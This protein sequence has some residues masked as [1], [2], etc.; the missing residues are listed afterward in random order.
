MSGME[1]DAYQLFLESGKYG[2]EYKRIFPLPTTAVWTKCLDEGTVRKV[3]HKAKR[4]V[5]SPLK[6]QISLRKQSSRHLHTQVRPSA[7]K[8]SYAFRLVVLIL[9]SQVYLGKLGRKTSM[10]S[11]NLVSNKRML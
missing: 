10:G 7:M 5:K 9:V 11:Q 6:P 1:R 3:D 2:E 4:P 8:R